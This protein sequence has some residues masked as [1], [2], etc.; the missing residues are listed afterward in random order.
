[1]A[2]CTKRAADTARRAPWRPARQGGAALLLLLAVA[3]LGAATLL[4]S[5]FGKQNLEA[6]RERRTQAR[7]AQAADALIGFAALHG[8]LPR[9]AV[10]ATD[11]RESAAPCDSEAA[12]SGFLPWVALGVEGADSW[13]KVLRYSVTPEYTRAPLLRISA[14][15]TKRVQTRDGRGNL[16]YAVG[17]EVCLLYAQCAPAVVFSQGRNNLGTSVSGMAQA[18]G[19]QGNVDEQ[20]NDGAVQSFMQRAASDNPAAPGGVFDDLLLPLSLPT[21][22]ERMAAARALP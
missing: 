4:I 12:C 22:Y 8:R 2:A 10:S 7:L 14:V 6:L 19:A 5:V 16:V 11:G 3:G 13:G 17:Q 1:M 18:N 9:P 21:L 20:G 15:A